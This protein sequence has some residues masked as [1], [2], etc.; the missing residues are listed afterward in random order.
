MKKRSVNKLIFYIVSAEAVGFLSAVFSGGFNDFYLSREKPPLLPPAWVFPL[1]WIILYAVM[2]FSAG[3]I[4]N[5]DSEGYEKKQA[6]RLYWIQLFVN[7]LWS[8]FFF[9]FEALTM[10][11]VT[12]IILFILILMMIY[13]FRKIIPLSGNI[14]IPYLVWTA[15]ATYLTIYISIQN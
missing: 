14:N 5:S 13:L 3:L 15:F 8:I 12:V 9:R 2:G 1:V 10:A 11:S 7:F 4:Q 6:L